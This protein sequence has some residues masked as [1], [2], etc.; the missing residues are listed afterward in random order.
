MPPNSD[1]Q[2]LTESLN[3]FADAFEKAQSAN[4]SSANIKVDAGGAGIWIATTCCA[5]M[6]SSFLIG[7]MWVSRE[8]IRSD[9]ERSE[10]REKLD[11]HQAYLNVL[12]QAEVKP[13]ANSKDS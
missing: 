3:R 7:A 11:V 12:M 5:V 10:I 4:R 8:F 2:Q 1:A 6:L 9:S 13:Q